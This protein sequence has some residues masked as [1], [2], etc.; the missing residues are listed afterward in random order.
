[1]VWV[2]SCTLAPDGYTE[3]ILELRVLIPVRT[4]NGRCLVP[5]ASLFFLVEI[6]MPGD[7]SATLMA[8]SSVKN[9]PWSGF[10]SPRAGRTARTSRALLPRHR[11]PLDMRVRKPAAARSPHPFSSPDVSLH[12]RFILE[13]GPWDYEGPSFPA[14]SQF[15]SWGLLKSFDWVK[16]LLHVC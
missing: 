8:G 1:M 2:V 9:R 11:G 5:W 10:S 15:F 6:N 3:L 13:S 16:W 14:N 12:D 7:R 4:S